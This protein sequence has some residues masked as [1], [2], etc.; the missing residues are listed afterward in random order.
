MSNESM[1]CPNLNSDT[2]E[3]GMKSCEMLAVTNTE[4]GNCNL[5][6]GTSVGD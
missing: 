4:T 1:L 5:G 6:I 3:D 2:E